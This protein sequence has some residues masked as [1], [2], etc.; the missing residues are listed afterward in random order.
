MNQFNIGDIV[1]I[2]KGKVEYRV[3]DIGSAFDGVQ[4]IE[5]LNT[6]KVTQ[7]HPSKFVLVSSKAE[8]I[9]KEADTQAQIAREAVEIG[10]LTSLYGRAI[11]GALQTKAHV[12]AGKVKSEKRRAKNRV[13]KASR[14]INR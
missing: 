9:E 4:S 6:G 2:G 7:V 11:L 12:F 8:E 13:A 10:H 3:L 5:S 1:R 14:K